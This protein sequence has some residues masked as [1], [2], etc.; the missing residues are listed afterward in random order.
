M[1]TGLSLL[2]LFIAY[3]EIII[4]ERKMRKIKNGDFLNAELFQL[5]KTIKL[6][7]SFWV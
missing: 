3:N 6:Y 4:L 7:S 1:V 5:K 2:F